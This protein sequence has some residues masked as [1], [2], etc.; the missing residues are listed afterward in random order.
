MCRFPFLSFYS[1]CYNKG[2]YY[3]MNRRIRKKLDKRYGCKTYLN[4]RRHRI[5]KVIEKYITGD[6]SLIL[7]TDN[8]RMNLK[9]P[10][11]IRLLNNVRPIAIDSGYIDKPINIQFTTNTIVNGAYAKLLKGVQTND[12]I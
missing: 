7:I 11:Q 10:Q 12:T 8:K 3:K 6:T 1:L 5:I 4:F 9:H 2:G